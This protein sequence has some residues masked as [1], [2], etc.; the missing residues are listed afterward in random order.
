MTVEHAAKLAEKYVYS[1]SYLVL[2]YRYVT[3]TI[4]IYIYMHY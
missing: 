1:I 4:A 2:H 3:L